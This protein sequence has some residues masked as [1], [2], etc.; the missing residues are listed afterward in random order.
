MVDLWIFGTLGFAVFPN[1]RIDLF[2][3]MPCYLNAEGGV[4]YHI[5]EAE[6]RLCP[7][8]QVIVVPSKI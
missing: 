8:A 6:P 3:K 1:K 7:R 4:F 2:G 5:L